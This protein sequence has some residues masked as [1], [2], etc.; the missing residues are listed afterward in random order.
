MVL[1]K[2]AFGSN[3]E[4]LK[5]EDFLGARSS[6]KLDQSRFE[7]STE[8]QTEQD[9]KLRFLIRARRLYL[10]KS[11]PANHRGLKFPRGKSGVLQKSPTPDIKYTTSDNNYDSNELDKQFL[12]DIATWI[13][14]F[15]IFVYVVAILAQ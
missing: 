3:E 6:E 10:P 11:F 1:L 15:I 4:K 14:F 13:L 12:K 2:F 9:A 7:V 5:L 8:T